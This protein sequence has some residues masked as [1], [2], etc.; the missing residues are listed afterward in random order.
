M[1]RGCFTVSGTGQLTF[2]TGGLHQS[3]SS[4]A[5]LRITKLK[6]PLLKKLVPNSLLGQEKEPLMSGSVGGF[7]RPNRLTKM[8]W[9][10]CLKTRAILVSSL[11]HPIENININDIK[12]T[13]EADELSILCFPAV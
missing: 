11:F 10:P 5:K 4:A 7:Q 6:A 3:S 13:A 2:S 8:L 12:A 1:V 9:L